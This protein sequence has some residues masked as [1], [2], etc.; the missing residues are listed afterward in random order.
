MV[1]SYVYVW[2]FNHKHHKKNDY[3]ICEQPLKIKLGAAKVP[4][5][6]SDLTALLALAAK[7]PFKSLINV[8]CLW[9]SHNIEINGMVT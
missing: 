6:V 8:V 7:H 4:V 9:V 1:R 2:L 5:P 3:I